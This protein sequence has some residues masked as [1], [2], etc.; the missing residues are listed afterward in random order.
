MGIIAVISKFKMTQHIAHLYLQDIDR[1]VVSA[2]TT[3]AALE[4]PHTLY[5]QP[6]P[7]AK[8]PLKRM[9]LPEILGSMP[10][11]LQDAKA[12]ERYKEH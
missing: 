8:V 10:V 11:F 6:E 12:P 7:I 3:T 1:Q 5:H 9:F 4:S 2:C